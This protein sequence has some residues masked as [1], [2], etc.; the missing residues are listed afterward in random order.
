M[1]LPSHELDDSGGLARSVR[2]PDID[3]RNQRK[4]PRERLFTGYGNDSSE[5]GPSPRGLGRMGRPF[6]LPAR[7]PVSNVP[8]QFASLERVRA[9]G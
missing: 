4:P 8:F 3:G 5:I 6:P 2:L 7:N 1:K 9:F